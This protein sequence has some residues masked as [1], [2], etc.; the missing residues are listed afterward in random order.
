VCASARFS[1]TDRPPPFLMILI[2]LR[3]ALP[4][5]ENTDGLRGS[6]YSD[7][8][9][10]S[11]QPESR[12][13]LMRIAVLADIHSNLPA[14]DAVLDDI[15]AAGV[16]AIVLNGDIATGPMPAETLDRLA[17]LHEEAIWVRG[18]ADRELVAAYDGRLNPN[19]PDAARLPTEY[20]LSRLDSRHRNF[21]RRF[22]IVDRDRDNRPKID[23]LRK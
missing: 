18:N 10:L 6:Q 21:A 13:L 16:D 2:D 9:N 19:L 15:D 20:C 8:R 22:A 1:A 7:E 11:W 17:G 4:G 23:E 14:L 3:K 5:Y 12:G